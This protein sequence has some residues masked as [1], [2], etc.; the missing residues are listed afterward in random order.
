MVQKVVHI[1]SE[2]EIHTLSHAVL[3]Y[4]QYD[5]TVD[6]SLSNRYSSSCEFDMSV[7]LVLSEDDIVYAS[8]S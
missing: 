8:W 1:D 3:R 7:G 4:D 6:V 2:V 5:K